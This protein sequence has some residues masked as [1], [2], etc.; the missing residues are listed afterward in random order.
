[1]L[2]GVPDNQPQHRKPLASDHI[3]TCLRVVFVS[4]G[5]RS[6]LFHTKRNTREKNS[7]KSRPAK[8]F[9]EAG[10]PQGTNYSQLRI[11]LW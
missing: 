2:S 3:E 4:L 5:V 9:S 7:L 8:Q 6:S 10:D 1:M 11:H